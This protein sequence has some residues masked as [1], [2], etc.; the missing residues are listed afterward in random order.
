MPL[1]LAVGFAM[2]VSYLLAST[3]VPV[4]CVALL[5]HMEHGDENAG[6]F[7]RLLYVYGKSVSW[8]VRLRWVVVPAYL[9]ACALVLWQLGLQVGTELFPQ[10]DSGRFVLRFRP[11]PGS[12]SS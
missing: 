2:I 9:G 5:R 7:G 8:L 6:L 12:S 3:F 11:P 10:V 1:T 4:L